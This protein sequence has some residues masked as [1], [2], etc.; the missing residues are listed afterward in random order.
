MALPFVGIAHPLQVT[1]YAQFK[2]RMAFEHI[3]GK[4][5][6]RSDKPYYGGFV[7]VSEGNGSG[8]TIS[9][10]ASL[11]FGITFPGQLNSFEFVFGPSGSLLNPQ[12]DVFGGYFSCP[13]APLCP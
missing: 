13:T 1:S 12:F 11:A 4:V 6:N 10:T 9:Q 3:T 7:R 8:S 5:I 2:D